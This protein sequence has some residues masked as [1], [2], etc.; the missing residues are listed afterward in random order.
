MFHVGK[1]FYFFSALQ[2]NFVR[3]IKHSL[4]PLSIVMDVPIASPISLT[5]NS[6]CRNRGKEKS[7]FGRE[8][9]Q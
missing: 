9:A 4:G 5:V 8:N 2:Q 6:N 1:Y 7:A 3:S